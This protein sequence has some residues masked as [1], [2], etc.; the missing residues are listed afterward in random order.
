MRKDYEIALIFNS[1]IP[2]EAVESAL[3]RYEDFL[4]TQNAEVVQVVRWGVRKLAYEIARH[5]QGM[6]VFIQ[7]Q[8]EPGVVAELDRFCRL[9]ESVLRYMIVVVEEGFG[10]GQ[11]GEGEADTEPEEK[12]TGDEEGGGSETD[13]EEETDA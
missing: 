6:Y 3:K 8:A 9:D 10:P 11:A 13:I 12:G 4:G 2:E 5:Q 7:F 1:Q